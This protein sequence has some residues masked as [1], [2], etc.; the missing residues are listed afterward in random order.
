MVNFSYELGQIMTRYDLL[1]GLDE[2]FWAIFEPTWTWPNFTE[3]TPVLFNN[4]NQ[5]EVEV[6]DYNVYKLYGSFYTQLYTLFCPILYESLW[7]FRNYK[8]CLK[9]PLQVVQQD[10]LEM[11]V[12]K[13]SW[14]RNVD[15]T[16]YLF[17]VSWYKMF[18]LF[19]DIAATNEKILFKVI[20][21][22]SFFINLYLLLK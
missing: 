6:F 2:W 21:Q 22:L 11:T 8:I 5:N 17:E 3:P 1:Y 15:A 13:C 12:S 20:I 7:Y 4:I 19:I 16:N 14:H 9:T 10:L 18:L